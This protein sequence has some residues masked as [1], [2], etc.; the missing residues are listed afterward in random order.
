MCQECIKNVKKLFPAIEEKH[1]SNLL[2]GCTC[3]PFGSAGDVLAQLKP[4]SRRYNRRKKTNGWQERWL[5]T[6]MGRADAELEKDMEKYFPGRE[7]G[8]WDRSKQGKSLE[9]R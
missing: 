6:E 8:M 4:M 5:N 2:M 9:G 1:L 7:M 3:F